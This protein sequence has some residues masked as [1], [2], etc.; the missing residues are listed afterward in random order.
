MKNT[1]AMTNVKGKTK[2]SKAK[3]SKAKT[4]QRND[5]PNIKTATKSN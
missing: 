5:N 1:N 4:I 3:Q 2:Q